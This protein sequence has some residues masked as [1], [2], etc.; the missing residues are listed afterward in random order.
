MAGSIATLA[1]EIAGELSGRFSQHRRMLRLTTRTGAQVLLAES[2]RGEEEVDKGFRLQLTA[3]SLDAGISLRSLLGQPVLVELMTAGPLNGR[4][5]FHG[6]VTAAELLGANGGFARYQL[7]IEPWTA[8]L[9]VGRDSRVFQD[10]T[11]FDILEAIF[12][13]YSG[14]GR[15]TPAWRF[16]I[17]DRRVY[18]QRSLVTQYQ[19]S[20]LAFVRRL[21]S[22]EGLF[23]FFEHA[24][25]PGSTDFGHHTLVI[26]DRN[27]VFVPNAQANVRYTQAGA[28]MEEDSLDRWRVEAR[29]QAN[30][31]ELVSWDYRARKR[32]TA[33]SGAYEGKILRSRDV[34]GAYA[35]S[36]ST[37]AQ[38]IADN[39]MQGLL[40]HAQTFVGAGTVRTFAP[41]TT[42]NLLGHDSC[43]GGA[44]DRYA[45]LRVCHLAHNNLAA[46]TGEELARLLGHNAL[47]QANDAD[48]ASNLHAAGRRGV[49]ER[50]DYR[51]RID[52][53]RSSVEYRPAHIDKH[54]SLL[55]PRPLVHGQQTAIVVGP[56]GSVIHTDRDHRIKVQ[57]HWQRGE[58]SHSRLG[59]PS[60]DGHTGAPADDRAGTWVR[61]ALPLAPVAG[62]NWGSHAL[63]RVGQEVLVDFMEG[64]ID[65]PVVIACLYN[66]RGQLDAQF[67]QAMVG[68]GAAVG[69]A[70]AWFAGEEGGHAHAATLSGIK[71]QAMSAS[72]EGMGGYGQLVFDDSAGQA[73]VSLQRHGKAHDGSAEL[74]LGYLR[75]QSDNQRRDQVGNGA[76]LKTEHAA[77]IRAG[78]G[79]LLSTTRANT[80]SAQL[81]AAPAA[82]QINQAADLLESLATTAHTHQARLD[83]EESPETLVP[84]KEL[85]RSAEI[86]QSTSD[87][88]RGQPAVA[89]G[90]SHMQLFSPAGIAAVTPSSAVF[91]A[92]TSV[93]ISA[94]QDINL[95]AQAN[96]CYV[97]KSGVV[98]F[99]YGKASNP[100]KP[101]QETGIRLH[102][103]SGKVSSQSQSGSTRLT[104]DKA[105]TVASVAKS[106]A[107]AAKKHVLLTA[108]GAYIKICGGDIEVH[109]PGKVDFKA[110]KKEL[111]GPTSS[112]TRL[113]KFPNSTIHSPNPWI[114][115][116]RLYADGS[117]VKGA[118]YRIKLGNGVTK[119][120]YLDDDGQARIEDI[121][122]GFASIEIGEDEREWAIDT[123]DEHVAN[124]AFGKDLT[125]EQLIELA[126]VATG[127]K[128]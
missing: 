74:N 10:K 90:A 46:E 26:A 102:A 40:A 48:L 91:S 97:A 121:K 79:L 115:I 16:D 110:T 15:L 66:G 59:H 22:E 116:E 127:G 61:V 98:L 42:F 112:R 23:F 105:I 1:S 103:A 50:P 124:P 95:V 2:L 119:C 89:Y 93:S 113:P 111:G 54:G 101:N 99:T 120:G 63:P 35:Y 13:S 30:A 55:H 128:S 94:E 8:F 123:P 31:V 6:H 21:M 107:V 39:R 65:R 3:L 87:G 9:D 96:C 68:A 67:N 49:G 106:V 37:Q 86:I 88:N 32:R 41:G 62:E 81:D 73:R 77:A 43:E 24:G 125:V 34:P 19:E 27:H 70:P 92:N 64:D 38:R 83:G 71:S 58:R 33:A 104:A 100:N 56:P 118:T 80:G 72:Q 14:K 76:E 18:P 44:A 51:N 60:P 47:Q 12:R 28:V 20:D 45:I 114:G 84:V 7:V 82:M 109:A 57:F 4:R 126:K 122:R 108:Q 25:N 29:M 52:A 11:V 78:R 117:P 53:I 85:R 69:S 36:S 5:P 75:H 17:A